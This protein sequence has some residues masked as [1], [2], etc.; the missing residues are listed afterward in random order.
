MEIALLFFFN[1]RHQENV[2]KWF[3]THWIVIED[4]DLRHQNLEP[5]RPDHQTSGSIYL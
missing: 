3:K 4:Q 2:E 1:L 5:T